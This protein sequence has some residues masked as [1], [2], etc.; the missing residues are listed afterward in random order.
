[1]SGEELTFSSR[2]KLDS[3]L[4][5]GGM[6]A[7][8]R[9]YDSVLRKNVA[10]KLLLPSLNQNMAVRFQQEAKT[11]AKLD[12]RN[13]IR[14]L[15]F[16]QTDKGEFYLIMEYLKG[17]TLEDMVK[18]KGPLDVDSALPIFEQICMG[19]QHAHSHGVLHR[20]VKPS[21]I[22]V[23]PESMHVTI[24]DFG[25]A[26]FLS[27]D[28]S[29]TGKG[30]PLGS[31]AYM[32]PEQAQ[33]QGVDVRSDIYSMGCLMYMTLVGNPPLH[34]ATSLE[35]I[36]K[37]IEDPAPLLN[38]QP[39]SGK[40]PDQ[41]EIIVEKALEKNPDDRFSDFGELREELSAV[42]KTKFIPTDESQQPTSPSVKVRRVTSWQ[43]PL[44]A[45]IGVIIMLVT[46]F[47]VLDTSGVLS[48]KK[49]PQQKRAQDF[50]FKR[51][52]G[53]LLYRPHWVLATG[54]LHKKGIK[55]LADFKHTDHL[56]LDDPKIN[57]DDL[58]FL[59]ALPLIALDVSHTR[60]TANGLSLNSMPKLRCLILND[61]KQIDDETISQNI[62]VFR[63][64][65]VLSLR[66]TSVTDKGVEELS[67]IPSLRGLDLEQLQEVTPKSL[68]Y[69][70]KMKNLRGLKL[71][72]TA[73][74]AN[75][76]EKLLKFPSL[77]YI[78]F[79]N[80]DVT[81]ASFDTLLKLQPL[82]INV[83]N[84]KITD[85][86]L[87]NLSKIN[88]PV[89]IEA[90]GCPQITKNEV[91]R[92]RDQFPPDQRFIDRIQSDFFDPSSSCGLSEEERDL[93]CMRNSLWY[94]PKNYQIQ[95]EPGYPKV[96]DHMSKI[97]NMLKNKR[98]G[99]ERLQLSPFIDMETL[100]KEID[101]G[102]ERHKDDIL[103]QR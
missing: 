17:Q 26:K 92:L 29:M 10:V 77:R 98:M 90:N 12:H 39:R 30:K 1:M 94:E 18:S 74:G 93:R 85:K 73:I 37:Q 102:L 50:K 63:N 24:V 62:Q 46:V 76:I 57:D 71:S 56:I 22:M 6:G 5:S 64:L 75:D 68:E 41:L 45:G 81:D 35:T 55:E 2:Y 70:S 8:Y 15:D 61:N 7:V 96:I 91:M 20:D 25:V 82:L 58:S 89:I 4:G 78:S 13:I 72:G 16:G 69:L 67:K 33:G 65:Q 28:M 21:N 27:E 53:Y 52:A 3:K 66:G 54:N 31:P 34:G 99:K 47:V 101:D 95:L 79:A 44:V 42:K 49:T 32:S 11:A 9:A 103:I 38:D 100:E 83:S 14:V 80:N 51:Y 84:S 23:D 88:Y 36:K 87:K 40:F 59:T 48:P 43:K 19:M 97:T 60:I 86:S